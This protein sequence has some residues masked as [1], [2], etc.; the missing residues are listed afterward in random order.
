MN[1]LK[2]FTNNTHSIQVKEY[3]YNYESIIKPMRPLFSDSLTNALKLPI[4]VANIMANPV[5]EQSQP[6]SS[7]DEFY[8]AIDHVSDDDDDEQSPEDDITELV[9]KFKPLTVWN[10]SEDNEVE[11]ILPPNFGKIRNNLLRLNF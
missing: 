4:A 5:C 8:D 2:L 9:V 11:Y 3:Y 7:D 1:L 6:L 10:N